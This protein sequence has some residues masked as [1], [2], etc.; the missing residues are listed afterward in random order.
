MVLLSNE[1]IEQ[2]VKDSLKEIGVAY[3]WV[4]VDPQFADTIVC[5]EKYGFE[6]DHTGNT[7]I[8]ASKRGEKKYAACIVRGVEKLD[9]NRKVRHLMGVS[10]LS[11]ANADD[12]LQVTQMMIGGVTPFGLPSAL[13][14]YIDD[15]IMN[16]DYLILG[17]GSRSAKLIVPP[18]SL[19]MI[20]NTFV[21]E[22]LS[23]ANT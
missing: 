1:E 15:T 9:V 23:Q 3:D 17:G 14:I 21:I 20:P 16:L 2:R 22:G 6:L 8:V 19:L 18:E 10:R 13:P 11:F 4:E 5:C 7:I 12:T